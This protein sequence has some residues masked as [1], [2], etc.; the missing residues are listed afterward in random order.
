[1]ATL[2]VSVKEAITLNNIDYGSERS[3]DI[4]F[5]G[6][7]LQ[8]TFGTHH[9]FLIQWSDSAVGSVYDNFSWVRLA[10]VPKFNQVANQVWNANVSLVEQF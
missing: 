5:M 7:V 1:M 9:P 10:D 8:R 6:N 4:S 3:L 2:T